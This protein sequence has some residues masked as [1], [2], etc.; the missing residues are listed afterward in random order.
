M[1]LNI[2]DILSNHSTNE[3][4]ANHVIQKKC[5]YIKNTYYKMVNHK[6][7]CWRKEIILFIF[8][9]PG[10]FLNAQSD[11]FIWD[12][13]VKPGTIEWQNLNCYEKKLNAYNIPDEILKKM[14]TANLVQTCLKY[15]EFRLIMTRN[16]L[17][18]GY[19]YLR[20]IFNGFI[21]LEKRS[22]AGKQILKEYRKIHPGDI[23]NFDTPLKRGEFAFNLTHIEILLAQKQIFL[24]L[25]MNSKK[26]LVKMGISNFEIIKQMPEHYA[27]LGLITPALMLGRLLDA[28]NQQEFITSKSAD[29]QLRRFISSSDL[30]DV[31][32]LNKILACSKDYLKQLENE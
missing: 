32:V 16:N 11:E 25:E 29:N 30:P 8:N 1:S 24:N 12:Y 21:E 17:Q 2:K 6:L 20:T 22:D 9:L 18:E 28:N 13:P 15:P 27:T 31:T 7:V 5:K 3:H 26:E 10:I 4:D 14:S 23:K 19:N